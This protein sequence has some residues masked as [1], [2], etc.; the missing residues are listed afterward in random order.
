MFGFPCFKAWR[1]AIILFIPAYFTALILPIF[2]FWQFLIVS[3]IL[4][5]AKEEVSPVFLIAAVGMIIVTIISYFLLIFLYSLLLE[6]LWSKPPQW[7]RPPQGFKKQFIHLGVATTATL[8]IVL[9]YV[10]YIIFIESIESLSQTNIKAIC[11]PNV[12]L[13]LSSIWLTAAAYLYQ[14]QY[15]L[16]QT[17]KN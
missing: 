6:L 10:I 13:K 11:P 17:K 5:L 1:K 7:L 14:W 3:V 2:I 8:P 12:M 9:I 16:K 15:F 4:F